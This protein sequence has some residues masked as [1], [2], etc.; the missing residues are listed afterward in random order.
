MRYMTTYWCLKENGRYEDTPW[1]P[2]AGRPLRYM[3]TQLLEQHDTLTIA[4]LCALLKAEGVI[5]PGRPSKV[6][7]DA[8]RWE[9]RRGRVKRLHRGV[10]QF[11][12]MAR[13]TKYRID[14]R[15]DAIKEF[16]RWALTNRRTTPPP[17]ANITQPYISGPPAPQVTDLARLYA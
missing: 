9:I 6:V 11:D 17:H 3:L 13:S 4:E 12:T 7:S 14:K 8:L 2:I 16:L 15:V 10:Y 5:L 1:S